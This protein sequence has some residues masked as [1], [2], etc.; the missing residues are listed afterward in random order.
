[1]KFLPLP[2]L[3]IEIAA[4]PE[5]VYQLIAAAGRGSLPGGASHGARLLE[6]PAPNRA[7]VEFTTRVFGRRVVTVEEVAFE[8]SQCIRYRLLSG[9]LPAVEEEFRLEPAPSGTALLYSGQYSPNGPLPRTL[10]DRVVV[11][12]IYRRVV[13][14]SM[15][16]IKTAAE[17]RQSKSRLFRGPAG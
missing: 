13:W 8:P 4:H 16:D 2:R 11:P 3:R 10:F 7:V 12:S 9:P 17:A 6:Q 5:L 1:M 14:K 15:L